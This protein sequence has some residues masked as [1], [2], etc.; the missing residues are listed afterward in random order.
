[1]HILLVKMS[2]M[3]DLLH[4]LPALTDAQNAIPELTIDWLVEPA[5][6]DIP[7]W[8]PAVANTIP[9]PLRQWRKN[10]FKT[11]CSGD[12]SNF[13]QI[14]QSKKYDAVIDAQGLLKSA[15]ITKLVDAHSHGFDRQSA[16]EP[17]S[18]I[19]YNKFMLYS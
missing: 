10:I 3:G 1:M 7:A 11:L 17:L 19:F 16:R 4:T 15:W 6:A 8:H 12:F 2:S 13:K 9:L 18:S 14:I 5:F